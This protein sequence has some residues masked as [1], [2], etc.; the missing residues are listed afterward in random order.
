M[1]AIILPYKRH[2]TDLI[3]KHGHENLGHMGQES[4]L[5]SLRETV[6]IVKGRSAVRRVVGRCITCQQQ[7]NACPGKRFMAD[8]PEVG[9]IPEKALFT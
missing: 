5:P 8:L 4:V 6:W 9:L 1:L 3:I 7:R 2:V